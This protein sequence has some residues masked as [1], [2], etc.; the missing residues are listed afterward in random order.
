MGQT[1]IRAPLLPYDD[2]TVIQKTTLY[3]LYEKKLKSKI[4]CGFQSR[5]II[6]VCK[7]STKKIRGPTQKIIFV[8]K[9]QQAVI[10]GQWGCK[11]NQTSAS[12]FGIIVSK[13][14]S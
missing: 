4:G 5:S 8:V 11:T 3:E 2:V 14:H 6:L 12:L 10:K 7:I 13:V 1:I 9:Q